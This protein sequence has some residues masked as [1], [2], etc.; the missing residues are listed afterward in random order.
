MSGSASARIVV[1]KRDIA[2]SAAAPAARCRNCRRGS[3][4]SIPPSLVCLFDHLVGAG[5]QRGGNFEA[6]CSGGLE[7]DEQFELRGLMYGKIG[8]SRPC[9][10]PTGIDA[11]LIA[12]IRIVT[13]I[14]HKAACRGECTKLIN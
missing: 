9:K 6:E 12:P 5:E 8:W 11:A 3:F 1:V 2:G 13:S 10:D 14:T 7:V 4:I